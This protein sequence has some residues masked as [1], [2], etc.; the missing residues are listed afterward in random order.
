MRPSRSK[1][2]KSWSWSE[3]EKMWATKAAMGWLS[4]MRRLFGYRS[5]LEV[6]SSAVSLRRATKRCF[7]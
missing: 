1:A 2:V 5:V 3:V 7:W 6:S 4:N